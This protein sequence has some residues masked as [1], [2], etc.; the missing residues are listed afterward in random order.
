MYKKYLGKTKIG[1]TRKVEEFTVIAVK[2]YLCIVE[3][4]KKNKK[5]LKIPYE[6]L[7]YPQFINIDNIDEEI[8]NKIKDFF[9]LNDE[10]ILVNFS[11]TEEK[12][13]TKIINENKREFDI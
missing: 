6:D 4:N 11:K 12:M 1:D 13:V 5:A 2:E 8:K 3:K 9:N 7:K 10:L